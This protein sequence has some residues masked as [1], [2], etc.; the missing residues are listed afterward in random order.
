MSFTYA[1][2]DPEN[3]ALLEAL[4]EAYAHAFNAP[5]EGVVERYRD[6]GAEAVR[7]VRDAS[8]ALVAGA[9]LIP[10]G[11]HFLGAR[12]PILGV[13]GVLVPPQARGRG[14]ARFLMTE[15]LG[16][17]RADARPLVTL[18][19]STVPLYRSVGFERAGGRWQLTCR[20]RD[21]PHARSACDV[22]PI[23]P[24][25]EAT[26][27]EL[28]TARARGLHGSLDWGP[29]MWSRVRTPRT[30]T[31]HGF[32]IVRRSDGEALGHA[33]LRFPAPLTYERVHLEDWSATT[34][35]AFATLLSLVGSHSTV[36]EELVAP[37]APDDPLLLSL[38]DRHYAFT[39]EEHWLLRLSD[40]PKALEARRW[41][42]G[43]RAT[44]SLEVSD[45]A[46]GDNQGI[47]TLAVAD[48]GATVER[49]ERADVAVRLDVRALAALYAGHATP[50]SLA[51]SGALHADEAASDLLTELFAS[52]APA[53]LQRF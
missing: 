22:R 4:A 7:V 10:M 47:W 32:L 30:G 31:A 33:Y 44:V 28:R 29:Y 20:T 43:V 8:G 42:A 18:Y 25:D 45:D 38:P 48:G 41:P 3:G 2:L 37:C 27:N 11:Q 17:A 9:V 53:M 36:T 46:C 24:E 13:A 21:L 23:T 15:I 12:V 26:V 52:P 50:R 1:A 6:L 49:T 39:C 40:V 14:V 16:E 19:A 5:R 51:L 35:E 34:P